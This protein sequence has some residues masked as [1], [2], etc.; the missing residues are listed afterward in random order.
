MNLEKGNLLYR[1]KAKDIYQTDQQE[2]VIVKFRDDITA[3]DGEKKEVMGLKGY[4]NSLISA[5]LFTILEN[6]GIKTQF[7]D[8]P[9][10]GFMLSHK[11]EMIPLEVITRNIAAGSLLKRFPFQE[12]QNFNPPII[13][14]D[15]KNDEYHDPMLN[16]DIILALG[17]ATSDELEIIR[18]ITI[19]INDVLKNFL[20]TRGLLFPD[21]KI[22]FGRDC[23]DNI[24]LGDEISPDTCRFWDRETKDILDKDLFRKGESG[25]IEAYQKVAN[26][27]L[28]EEDKKKWS[29]NF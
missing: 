5:K 3:G 20:E 11:L 28:D 9:E 2:Q 8:L 14:M 24:V 12:G 17:L 16:D 29:L 18:K 4:Y 26:M 13:Q 1:G 25:V 19:K 10:P 22:E 21:F 6:A 27:I 23:D 15:F 7:I